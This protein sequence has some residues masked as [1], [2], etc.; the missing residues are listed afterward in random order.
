MSAERNPSAVRNLR[1]LFENKQQEDPSPS[2][3]GRSPIGRL[4]SSRDSNSSP[5]SRVRASFVSVDRSGHMAVSAEQDRESS[6][7]TKR[8]SGGTTED[9][10]VAGKE[11]M[12][13]T[14]SKASIFGN[15]TKAD[16]S[17]VDT[18]AATPAAERTEADTMA[19][20]IG[21]AIKPNGLPIDHASE[22]ESPATLDK[23]VRTAEA[24]DRPPKAEQRLSHVFVNIQE[25]S[26]PVQEPTATSKAEQSKTESS[27][28]IDAQAGAAQSTPQ[29]TPAPAASKA[30]KSPSKPSSVSTKSS[31]K[32]PASLKSPVPANQPKSPLSAKQRSPKSDS[33]RVIDRKAS[34]SSLTAPTAAS[35]ARAASS[36]K[37]ESLA[38]KTHDTTAK[39]RPREPTKA[40]DVSS[41]LLAPTA[42]SRARHEAETTAKPSAPAHKALPARPKPSSSSAKPTPRG[43]LAAP[44]RPE[45]RS[46]QPASRKAAAPPDGSF[47]DRMT[48]PTASSASRVHDKVEVKSPPRKKGSAPSKPNGMANTG[49]KVVD[50]IKDAAGKVKER[51]T[52]DEAKATGVNGY[53][54]E[55]AHDAHGVEAKVNGVDHR[56]EQEGTATPV[57]NSGDTA[58]GAAL[59]ATPAFGEQE[60]R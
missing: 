11:V 24:T 31:S 49:S 33:A 39:S 50:K 35:V 10:S 52:G 7:S 27:G 37:R 55:H 34:R 8:E 6:M 16:E 44:A 9:G 38:H 59:E 45:S 60:I 43:S 20:S 57:T 58:A 1:S 28:P 30:A 48:R 40:A 26:Q 15:G 56:A 12:N 23:P 32:V 42:A 29:Q 53:A 3:R 47:L 14:P 17:A 4:G 2:T 5:L 22:N 13:G 41:R 19:G 51:V 54:N 46:S 21:A 18:P 36:E 25:D